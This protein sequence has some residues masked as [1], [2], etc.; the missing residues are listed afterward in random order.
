MINFVQLE[1]KDGIN[2]DSSRNI[3]VFGGQGVGKSEIIKHFSGVDRHLNIK[4]LD[5]QYVSLKQ[6]ICM[7]HIIW[8]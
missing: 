6:I 7:M 8:Y 4:A 2:F 3:T 5:Q 1:E